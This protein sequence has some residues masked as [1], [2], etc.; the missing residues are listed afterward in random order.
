[1]HLLEVEAPGI[2][3]D[4]LH[5]SFTVTQ[6][7]LSD[8]RVELQRPEAGL[9]VTG[10]VPFEQTGATGPDAPFSIAVD[11]VTW[12]YRELAAWL[13]AALPLDGRLS[14]SIRIWGDPNR[15]SG[16]AEVA[17]DS[18]TVSGLE[19]ESLS[20]L[21]AFNPEGVEVERLQLVTA[22]GEVAA[23]GA[24]GWDGQDLTL[25]LSSGNLALAREPF[26]LWMSG[27]VAGN[28]KVEGSA[29]GSLDR[30]SADLRLE[31]TALE[32]AGRPLG[33]E[34]AAELSLSLAGSQLRAE[35]SLLGLVKLRGGG[36]ASLERVDLTFDL[37]SEDLRGLGQVFYSG[38]LPEIDGSL[39]GE[40]RV[41][42]GGENL[43]GW[44]A[45]LRLDSLVA[46]LDGKRLQNVQDV[47]VSLRPGQVLVEDLYL[48]DAPGDSELIL[49]GGIGLGDE[50]PLDL[51]AQSSL[52]AEWLRMVVPALDLRRGSI[53]LL[54]RIRGSL[55]EPEVDGQA[56]LRDGQVVLPGLPHALND[57]HAVALFYPDRIVLDSARAGFAGGSVQASGSLSQLLAEEGP[58]Y[59]LQLAGQRLSLRYPE[60]WLLQGSPELVIESVPGGREIR[61][62]VHLEDALYLRDVSV[63]VGQLLRG[64]FE[65]QRMEVETAD[66]LL[67]TTQLNVLIEGE[68]ALQIRNNLANLRGDLDL[69]LRGSLARPVAFGV[70]QVD[71]GGTL[72]WSDNEYQVQQAR[73]TFAN[74]RR[75]LPILDLVARAEIREYD[76]ILNLSGTLDRLNATFSSD[77]PMADLEVLALMATGQTGLLSEG[78][79]RRTSASVAA[80]TFLYG[81]ATS[82]IADR[83]NKLFGLDTLRLDPL[84]SATG[85]LSSARVTLGEQI[86]RD[87]F[88]TYTYDPSD[89]SEQIL[90][91]EWA[92]SKVLTLVVTQNGDGT[93]AVDARWQKEL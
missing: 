70:V 52:S 73:L 8:L 88:A 63:G 69:T 37:A 3:A 19:V 83:V 7:G 86:S 62:R 23:Q 21:I 26:S 61:G 29:A 56:E 43:Q 40:L 80:E 45:E 41:T 60:G 49:V 51:R 84:T 89:T 47:R 55:L 15:P 34:G 85:D 6:Q 68:D 66:E 22:A 46:V 13:P 53:D 48:A 1:M 16:R 30:P 44:L 38:E 20:A 2:I 5:G 36:E 25:S 79:S 12:P 67:I 32:L 50:L 57:L 77:P 75:I 28:L 11:A 14:G 87:L 71:P 18:A 93:Y 65:R 54:A 82:L 81:Q 42:A 9:I 17:L 92:V 10:S 39:G 35:G 78:R 91:L 74:P 64:L 33:R 59:R 4:G 58:S 24:M 76:V 90:Q 31:A 27:E 72:V